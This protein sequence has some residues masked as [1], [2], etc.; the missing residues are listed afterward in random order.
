MLKCV[1]LLKF[2][3]VN[4]CIS[5]TLERELAPLDGLLEFLSLSL[6]LSLS[7]TLSFCLSVCLSLSSLLYFLIPTLQQFLEGEHSEENIHFWKDV[8]DFKVTLESNVSS[9][10]THTN[11]DHIISY[12][13]YVFR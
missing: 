13:V 10:L 6:S 1:L 8:Q 5:E 9:P 12:N 2:K 11:C 3:I 4:I 7:L